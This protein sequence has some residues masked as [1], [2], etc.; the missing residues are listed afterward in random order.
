[1]TLQD[2]NDLLNRLPNMPIAEVDSL[3]AKMLN[4]GTAG[5]TDLRPDEK[6]ELLARLLQKREAQQHRKQAE[7]GTEPGRTRGG[8]RTAFARNCPQRRSGT[9]LRTGAGLVSGTVA[10]R[11]AFLQRS[12]PVWSQ[13]KARCRTSSPQYRSGCQSTRGAANHLSIDRWTARSANRTGGALELFV[14]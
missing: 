3:L 10:A 12:G 1:M 11:D 6:R 5:V 14:S 13:R 2:V 9:V 8:R 4:G 7:Q